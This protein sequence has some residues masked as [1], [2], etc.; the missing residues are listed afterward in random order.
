VEDG[1]V[2]F[3]ILRPAR[4]AVPADSQVRATVFGLE[5]A[6]AVPVQPAA[7]Q[8]AAAGRTRRRLVRPAFSSAGG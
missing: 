8:L 5:Q 6:A 1:T 7:V 3:G 4:I 2:R